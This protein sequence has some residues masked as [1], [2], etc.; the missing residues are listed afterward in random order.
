MFL[1]PARVCTLRS[2][3]CATV[4]LFSVLAYLCAG[5]WLLTFGRKIHCCVFRFVMCCRA[6]VVVVVVVVGGWVG[7]G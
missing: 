2:W 6:V 1:C 4:Q 3:S 5:D 7:G